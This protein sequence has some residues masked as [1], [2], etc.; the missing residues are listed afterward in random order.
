M[1][2]LIA[3][4]SM[5]LWAT[6]LSGCGGGDANASEIAQPEVHKLHFILRPDQHGF[7]FVQDDI[8]HAPV[9][10]VT[11]VEQ[12]REYLRVYFLRS[13][14]HAGTVQ[15]TPDDDFH[16]YITAG[17]N[18]GLASVT[19]RLKANG[20]PISPFEIYSHGPTVGSGNLWVN[21]TMVNKR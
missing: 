11:K 8:D 6:S 12:T 10:V 17:S 9:G 21:V 13:Y 1:K 16:G 18:L 2:K 19:I 3:L 5:A 15:V 20:V 7:W 14:S 4:L